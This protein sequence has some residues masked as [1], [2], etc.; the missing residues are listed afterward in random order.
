M[1]P[2]EQFTPHFRDMMHKAGITEEQV[3]M[4]GPPVKVK[5][6][7]GDGS[8]DLDPLDDEQESGNN[9][10]SDDDQ[11]STASN[12]DFVDLNCSID[13]DSDEDFDST[14]DYE[15]EAGDSKVKRSK[16]KDFISM[17][18][19]A[20]QKSTR[21][22]M[23]TVLDMVSNIND[24]RILAENLDIWKPKDVDFSRLESRKNQKN[25]V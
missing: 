2:K 9:E 20:D 11:Q 19:S 15:H 7:S 21:N 17:Q 4:P 14:G 24:A 13:L 6:Y 5:L 10:G 1:S 23:T 12:I 22:F 8:I 16:T 18:R 25:S 3:R